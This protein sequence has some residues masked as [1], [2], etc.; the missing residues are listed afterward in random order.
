MAP[1]LKH[2]WDLITSNKNRL[3][4]W[5]QA[6]FMVAGMVT[7]ISVS[8]GI[9]AGYSLARLRLKGAETFGSSEFITYLVPPSLLFL[10][11][12]R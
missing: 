7:F 3:F 10:P 6:S 1:T 2:Y 9:L 5:M 12:R 11:C 4:Y 8:I